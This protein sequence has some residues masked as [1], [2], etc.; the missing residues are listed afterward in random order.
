M[1]YN[2]FDNLNASIHCQYIRLDIR[3]YSLKLGVIF[4]DLHVY[5]GCD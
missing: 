4:I 1:I 3:L 2:I 5:Q